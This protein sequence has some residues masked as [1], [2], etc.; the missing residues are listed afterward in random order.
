[1]QRDRRSALVAASS[2]T[3]APRR[4]RIA[5]VA[6]PLDPRPPSAAG[7]TERIVHELTTELVRRGHDVTVFASGDSEVPGRLVPTVEKALR[8]AGVEGDAGGWFRATVQQVAEQATE[9]DVVHSHLEWWSVPLA[10][11][12]PVPVVATFH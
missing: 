1:M 4:L 3:D 8:P 9:F 5:Q 11:L 7:G 10:R 6:P 2:M 12:A